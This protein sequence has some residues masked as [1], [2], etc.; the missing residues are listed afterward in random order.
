MRGRAGLR[1]PADHSNP[2]LKFSKVESFHPERALKALPTK[3]SPL[4]KL[5]TH[6][7]TIVSSIP[8]NESQSTRVLSH[9]ALFLF[10]TAHSQTPCT[11]VTLFT[12][13][14]SS[15]AHTPL[16]KVETCQMD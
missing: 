6:R 15:R 8:A 12:H 13:C 10:A 2:V 16:T 3:T 7:L 9:L 5:E 4:L 11:L 1:T 14:R